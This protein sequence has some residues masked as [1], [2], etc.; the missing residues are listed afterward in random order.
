MLKYVVQ[1]LLVDLLMLINLTSCMMSDE[2]KR[3]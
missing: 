2:S 3:N 1:V